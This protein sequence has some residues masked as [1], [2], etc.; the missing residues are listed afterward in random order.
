MEPLLAV[1]GS[2]VSDN[3][4]QVVSRSL[5]EAIAVTY[6]LT[7]NG[8]QVDLALEDNRGVRARLRGVAGE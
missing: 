6:V 5:L 4:F 7:F 2:W 8:S 3:S 1:K